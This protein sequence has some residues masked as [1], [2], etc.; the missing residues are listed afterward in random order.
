MNGGEVGECG[1]GKRGEFMDNEGRR[2]SVMGVR[3]SDGMGSD[4][5]ERKRSD[6]K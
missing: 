2:R 6:E 3:A 1:E 5:R 4:G